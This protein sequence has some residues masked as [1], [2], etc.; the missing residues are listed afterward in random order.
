MALTFNFA[1]ASA[2]SEALSIALPHIQP[3]A[4]AVMTFDPMQILGAFASMG[5]GLEA[6]V[7]KEFMKLGFKY[8]IFSFVANNVPFK[9][10]FTFMGIT[11]KVI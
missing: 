4:D 3:L 1:N 6:G 5:T 9:R 7:M 11:F 2:F 10:E 8:G